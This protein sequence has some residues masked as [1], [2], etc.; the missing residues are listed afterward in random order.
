[1][2]KT[3]HRLSYVCT[4][5]EG[6]LLCIKNPAHGGFTNCNSNKIFVIKAPTSFTVEYYV[7]LATTN[8]REKKEIPF[9][10]ACLHF[11]LLLQLKGLSSSSFCM[12]RRSREKILISFCNH[13]FRFS[14]LPASCHRRRLCAARH[15][16]ARE[17]LP[18]HKEMMMMFD[19]FEQMVSFPILCG[20]FLLSGVRNGS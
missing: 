17:T 9:F 10:P 7:D 15:T 11:P 6:L 20:P 5:E 1:M 12:Q 3:L 18:K 19:V 8:S 4:C 2:P 14:Q 13:C 16:C